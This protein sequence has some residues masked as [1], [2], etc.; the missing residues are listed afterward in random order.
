GS[1]ILE[2]IGQVAAIACAVRRCNAVRRANAI[3]KTRRACPFGST[4][5]VE[6]ALS[7]LHTSLRRAAVAPV[8]VGA[9]RGRAAR[10]EFRTRRAAAVELRAVDDR[11]PIGLRSRDLRTSDLGS[12]HLSLRTSDLRTRRLQPL[13]RLRAG[14]AA[15]ARRLL[16][17]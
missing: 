11:R 13:R 6:R 10:A 4:S 17:A 15:D 2:S 8:E 3:G 9:Q 16:D 1:P 7:A 5:P 12:R 14:H